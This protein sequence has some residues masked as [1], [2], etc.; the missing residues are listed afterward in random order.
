MDEERTTACGMRFVRSSLSDPRLECCS[1]LV[2]SFLSLTSG[3]KIVSRS[4][5]FSSHLGNLSSRQ[6]E[7]R[8]FVEGT[9]TRVCPPRGY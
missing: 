7:P 4:F 1:C 3:G 9:R 2:L 5:S 8:A 6:A